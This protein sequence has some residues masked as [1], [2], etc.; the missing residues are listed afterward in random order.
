MKTA[1]QLLA[2]IR[3][4]KTQKQSLEKENEELSKKRNELEEEY[5]RLQFKAQWLEEKLNLNLSKRYGKSSEKGCKGQIELD[6][7]NEA[8]SESSSSVSEPEIEDVVVKEHKRKKKRSPKDAYKNLPVERIEHDIPEEDKVCPKCG[9]EMHKMSEEVVRHIEV[10]PAQFKVVEDVYPIYSCRNCEKNGINTPIKMSPKELLLIPRSLVSPSL[11]AYIMSQKFVN[12]LPLYRQEQE[13]RRNGLNLSRQTTANWV[14][15]GGNLLKPLYDYMHK[16]LVKKEVLHAD[17]T[18]LQ[19]LNEQD[20]SYDMKSY[21]WLYRTSGCEIPIVMYEY[22]EGKS[23]LFAKE[24]L[25]GFSGYLHTDG[26]SGYNRLKDQVKLCGCWA[27]MRRKFN[28]SLITKK[29]PP[30]DCPEKTALKYCEKLA[31]IEKSA[32]D[33]TNEDRY[34]IRQDK[35]QKIIDDFFEWVKK[36][37][38]NLKVPQSLLGTAYTYAINQE[39]KLRRFLEDG[40]IEMTNNRAERSIKPFVMGRKNW[41]F[42]NTAKGAKASAIVYSIIETAKENGLNPYEYLKWVFEQIRE[43]NDQPEMLAPW[44]MELKE[45]FPCLQT[46]EE[47]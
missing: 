35:S 12:H 22:Q 46:K 24:F 3:I 28:D 32:N 7:F 34:R 18:E 16:E 40:R 26:Y 19:V 6:I 43:G 5:E 4:L 31:R 21:M 47:K 27:H 25:D 33:M 45:K 20:R 44:N 30:D 36:E 41:L 29:T 9:K 17:E 1:E 8:E 38:A 39:Y 2:E 14:I 15:A 23:G 10:I 13:F 37:Q 42:C 11:M